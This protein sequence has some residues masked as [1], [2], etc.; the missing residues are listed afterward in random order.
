M[1]LS[2]SSSTIFSTSPQKFPDFVTLRLSPD[3]KRRNSL[4][5]RPCLVIKTSTG[6]FCS[7]NEDAINQKKK[8]VFA[9]DKGMPLT[10]VRVMSEPS[11]IPPFWSSKFLAKLTQGLLLE[12]VIPNCSWEITFTQPV[13]DYMEFRRRL[14]DL[15]VSLENVI[16][17]ESENA[18][19]GTV[20]VNNMSFEK[21]V[22][23]RYS[24]DHWLSHNDHNCSYVPNTDLSGIAQSTYVLFDTFSFK[25]ALPKKSQILE[26]CV[27]YKCCNNEY[28]DNNNSKN[29]LLKKKMHH[30]PR[31]ISSDN[32]FSSQNHD[33]NYQNHYD[34]DYSNSWSDFTTSYSYECSS[35]YW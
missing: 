10:Q 5:R 24:I 8:V 20:K 9:D 30:S 3:T 32:L 7:K 13:S 4:P 12:P 1:L 15:K 23:I 18:I 25:L 17:K 16:I 35:P 21:E 31:S 29:Y 22:I 14:D 2:R 6:I 26:F 34:S 28:W 27:C 33:R 11:Y 19:V